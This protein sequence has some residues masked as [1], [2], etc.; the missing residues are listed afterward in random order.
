LSF[1][2]QFTST[3]KESSLSLSLR[4]CSPTPDISGISSLC[5]FPFFFPFH[6][7]IFFFQ[8]PQGSRLTL[9]DDSHGPK[10][11][12]TFYLE[13][14][15]YLL[16]NGVRELW[17][18]DEKALPQQVTGNWWEHPFWNPVSKNSPGLEYQVKT[19]DLLPTPQE[20]EGV[21]VAV[22]AAGRTPPV[23][24]YF[25]RSRKPQTE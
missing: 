8:F 2:G 24:P 11:V 3:E 21:A 10:D 9:S 6:P 7:N 5:S 17:Y 22:T 25:S 1:R 14:K 19:L 16:E 12:G 13:T 15:N 23:L 20:E 18:L 4:R